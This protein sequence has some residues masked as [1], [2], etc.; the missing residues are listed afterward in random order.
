MLVSMQTLLALYSSSKGK[1]G[2]LMIFLA[3]FTIHCRALQ[4]KALRLPKYIVIKLVKPKPNQNTRHCT[5]EER[6]HDECWSSGAFQLP[7]EA[8]SQLGFLDQ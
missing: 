6:V 2:A 1:S 5:M 7:E 4:F 8:E 3:A